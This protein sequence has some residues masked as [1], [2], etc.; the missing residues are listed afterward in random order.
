MS[1]TFSPL[2]NYWCVE[3]DLRAC[4][5]PKGKPAPHW[6]GESKAELEGSCFWKTV[7]KYFGPKERPVQTS[8]HRDLTRHISPVLQS[9]PSVAHPQLAHF[10]PRFGHSRHRRLVAAGSLPSSPEQRGQPPFG[11]QPM[12]C[13]A[14]CRH[15]GLP[16]D[17]HDSVPLPHPNPPT[18][19]PPLDNLCAVCPCLAAVLLDAILVVAHSPFTQTIFGSDLCCPCPRAA[20]DCA[21]ALTVY[22]EH[23]PPSHVACGSTDVPPPPRPLTSTRLGRHVCE[24]QLRQP[25]PLCS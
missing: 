17:T 24:L 7:K 3:G 19:D 23:L 11:P 9:A 4:V 8:S 12:S 13:S 6:K 20:G 22:C 2:K 5:G 16:N 10:E 18:R 15:I 21:T 25:S 14:T 1:P